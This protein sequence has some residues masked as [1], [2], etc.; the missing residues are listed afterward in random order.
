M[1]VS[2]A[3]DVAFL[4]GAAPRS[5][6][7]VWPRARLRARA[8]PEPHLSS[9]APTERWTSAAARV[10]RTLST[11][12]AVGLVS[13]AAAL[14]SGPPRKSRARRRSS[15]STGEQGVPVGG[16]TRRNLFSGLALA[17]AATEDRADAEVDR[18]PPN[19]VLDANPVMR[20]FALRFVECQ[21]ALEQPGSLDSK[22][23][24]G[25]IATILDFFS[26]NVWDEVGPI[27]ARE[28]EIWRSADFPAEGAVLKKADARF[29]KDYYTFWGAFNNMFDAL[30]LRMDPTLPLARDR[31]IKPS[32]DDLVDVD[33]RG[34][35]KQ[36]GVFGGKVAMLPGLFAGIRVLRPLFSSQPTEYAARAVATIRTFCQDGKYM[37]G[38]GALIDVQV[39][40]LGLL[41]AVG[42]GEAP[43]ESAALEALQVWPQRASVTNVEAS[44]V[45]LL[46]RMQG[47]FLFV[48]SFQEEVV[49][50]L[51]EAK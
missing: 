14:V 13:A 43:K 50:S 48:N 32:I 45:Q 49:D 26:S 10:Q 30:L 5:A 37:D 29:L 16:A 51:G 24:A 39:E 15:L 17:G 27:G 46:Y 31:L 28:R 42:G 34:R 21:R 38:L 33:Q 9:S 20:K 4:A 47:V 6:P 19:L 1:R 25:T 3:S 11:K 12:V 40:L 8:G 41:Q 22:L 35:E 18:A 2:F 44:V 7:A 23:V 36:A